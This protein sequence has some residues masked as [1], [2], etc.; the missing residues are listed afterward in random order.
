VPTQDEAGC[1]G[2]FTQL[3]ADFEGGHDPGWPGVRVRG[4]PGP[5]EG[6][7][8]SDMAGAMPSNVAPL[9]PVIRL[10]LFLFWP[11]N[12]FVFNLTAN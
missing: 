3:F 12:T 9:A 4:T 11:G 6:D 10:V 5:S 8:D 2:E 7:G 1:A